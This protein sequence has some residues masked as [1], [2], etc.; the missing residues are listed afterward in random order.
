MDEELEE[1]RMRPEDLTL[2][3]WAKVEVLWKE[4]NEVLDLAINCYRIDRENGHQPHP[5]IVTQGFAAGVLSMGL[6]ELRALVH[7]AI[8]RIEVMRLEKEAG[9]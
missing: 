1:F 9:L 3:D 7:A 5:A 2:E 4:S 6:E 8:H